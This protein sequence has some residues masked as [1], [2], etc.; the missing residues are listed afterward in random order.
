MPWRFW[1]PGYSQQPSG[2]LSP[3][4]A[5]ACLMST[6][7]TCSRARKCDLFFPSWLRLG[8]VAHG[9]EG[10]WAL[11]ERARDAVP[12]EPVGDEITVPRRDN[13]PLWMSYRYATNVANLGGLTGCVQVWSVAHACADRSCNGCG[14]WLAP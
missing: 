4:Q 5:F 1:P 7:S 11:A 9:L 2:F 6:P 3:A 8:C 13:C 14:D 12:T 10:I